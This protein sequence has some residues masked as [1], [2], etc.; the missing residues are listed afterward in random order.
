VHRRTIRRSAVIT[1]V[2]ATG[3]LIAGC[4][5]A[6]PGKFTGG[7][8]LPSGASNNRTAT[9]PTKLSTT[10]PKAS[11]GFV[12]NGLF[13]NL[14]VS[15]PGGPTGGTGKFNGTYHDKA[16]G[17]QVSFDGAMLDFFGSPPQCSGT[18][19]SATPE[20]TTSGYFLYRPQVDGYTGGS[21]EGYI[22]I[23]DSGKPGTTIDGDYICIYLEGYYSYF[24]QGT[25]SGGNIQVHKQ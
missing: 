9:G 19:A 3:A 25:V 24:N 14:L 20:N 1:A 21:D 4:S 12:F 18:P 10:A 11:F 2:V 23:V 15:S 5:A 8:Y 16:A 13:T 22:K 7:G 17:V 6:G